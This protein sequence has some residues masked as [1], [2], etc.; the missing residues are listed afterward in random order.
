MTTPSARLALALLLAVGVGPALAE[1]ESPEAHA[2][3]TTQTITLDG[4]DVRPSTTNMGHDDIISFVNYSTHP[5][6]ITFTEPSDLEKKIRCGLVKGKEQ[7]N[8]PS[9]PWALFTWQDGKLVGNVPPG[10]FASVCSLEPGGYAFTA[11]I[12]GHRGDAGTT[13]TL[14]AKGRIEVK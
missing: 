1:P 11:Q 7:K 13:G 9:A 4:N 8:T 5:I 12:V 10:K 3:G 14:P 6:Q 2:K